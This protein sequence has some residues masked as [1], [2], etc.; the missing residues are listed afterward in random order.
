MNDAYANSLS[1]TSATCRPTLR[2]G[3]RSSRRQPPRLLRLALSGGAVVGLPK[4][5][6]SGV[7]WGWY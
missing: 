2:P 7:V 1:L 6:R 4:R 5:R 3:L